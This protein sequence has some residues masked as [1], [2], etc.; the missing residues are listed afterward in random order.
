MLG[1]C[2]KKQ[3]L[4]VIFFIL[5]ASIL[6]INQNRFFDNN[7][8]NYNL[9]TFYNNKYVNAKSIS[10]DNVDLGDRL[11][12]IQNYTEITT[13][14]KDKYI[15]PLQNTVISNGGKLT[16]GKIE[17]I[18]YLFKCNDVS[19]KKYIQKQLGLKFDEK[20]LL[21]LNQNID[22]TEHTD[23]NITVSVVYDS[24]QFIVTKKNLFGESKYNCEIISASKILIK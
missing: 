23:V 9:E 1:V 8:F 20:K 11:K 24:Y 2:M 17:M 18:N 22:I 12:K 16:I 14:Y 7:N 15:Y 13:P 4:L 19:I 5:I 10:I 6:I 3:F 21:E